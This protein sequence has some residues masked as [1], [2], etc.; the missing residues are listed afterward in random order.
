MCCT[1]LAGNAGSKKSPK[2]GRLGTIAQLC[3]A[4]SSQLPGKARIDN[5]KKLVKQH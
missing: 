4:I 3:W 2:I 1:Q 5:P